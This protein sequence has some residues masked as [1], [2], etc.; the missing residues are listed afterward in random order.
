MPKNVKYKLRRDVTQEQFFW[1]EQDLK[2]GTVLYEHKGQ[3]YFYLKGC[4][5]PVVIEPNRFPFFDV[6]AE[7]GLLIEK[8]KP[9]KYR[10]FVDEPSSKK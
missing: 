8:R 9:K 3:A 1:L 5:R 7:R 2:K 4:K 10:L 6:L